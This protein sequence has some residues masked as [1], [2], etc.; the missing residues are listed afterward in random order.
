MKKI[1]FIFS[2]WISVMGSLVHAQNTTVTS[3]TNLVQF[4]GV[5]LDQDSLTPIPFV[6]ILIKGTNRGTVTNYY[7]FFSLVVNPGDELQFFSINHKNRVYKIADTLKQKYYYALQVL[8]KD[9]IELK[10]VDV[11]PWPSREDFRRAFLALDLKDTDFERAERNMNKETLT[12]LERTQGND[13]AANYKVA[14]QNYYTKVYTS[15]QSPSIK[16]LDPIA[17]ANFIDAWRKGKY[18]KKKN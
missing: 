16:L 12:Y 11:Y 3:G 13:A 8:T 7:G 5:V 2:L 17:W 15:G 18:S 1:A 4:S 14:M 6:S 9:T 10:A